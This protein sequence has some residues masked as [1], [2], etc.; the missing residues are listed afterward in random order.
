M[1]EAIRDAVDA[2][3]ARL[4]AP[5]PGTSV[6]N[7]AAGNINDLALTAD[8][9]LP[10]WVFTIVHATVRAHEAAAAAASTS[11]AGDAPSCLNVHANMD[12]MCWFHTP[13]PTAPHL[14]SE[15]QFHLANF[16]AALAVRL[17]LLHAHMDSMQIVKNALVHFV[18]SSFY[19]L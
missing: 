9:L 8:D 12:Y 15:L 19:H 5:L 7:P 18:F 2:E 11:A 4:R 13:P 6:P 1:S 17:L 16:Q 14:T 10:L 3:V